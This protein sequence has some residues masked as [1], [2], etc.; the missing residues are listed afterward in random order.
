MSIKKIPLRMCLGCLA[1]KE[2]K[3]L[4]R[5]TK[6]SDGHIILDQSGKHPGRGTYI[7]KDKDCFQRV[8][9]V[10]KLEKVFKEPIK[11]GLIQAID[12]ELEGLNGS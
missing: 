10:K 8:L 2:K 9:K 7:C 4:L 11:E 5:L 1:R 3:E 6:S 12:R